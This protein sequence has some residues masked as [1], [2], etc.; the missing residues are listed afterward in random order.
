MITTSSFGIERLLGSKPLLING[1]ICMI[2]YTQPWPYNTILSF[3]KKILLTKS[4]RLWGSDLPKIHTLTYGIFIRNGTITSSR[5]LTHKTSKNC[6]WLGW[7]LLGC[8]PT[9]MNPAWKEK[10]RITTPSSASLTLDPTWAT[11]MSQGLQIK[12]KANIHEASSFIV[13]ICKR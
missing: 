9:Q 10:M 13:A 12:E 5:P 11:N 8:W 2:I 6:E 1:M 7:L 4:S 3:W